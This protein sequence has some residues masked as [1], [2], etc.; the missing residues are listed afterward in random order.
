M[1]RLVKI[2]FHV[3]LWIVRLGLGPYVCYDTSD[4]T[5]GLETVLPLRGFQR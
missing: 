2:K 5:S 3:T 1:R 4:R